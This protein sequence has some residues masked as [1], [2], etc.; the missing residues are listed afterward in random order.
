MSTPEQLGRWVVASATKHFYSQRGSTKMFIEGQNRDTDGLQVWYEFRLD[1]PFTILTT[2][3]QA[4]LDIEVNILITVLEANRDVYK[5]HEE[6]SKVA[7]MFS[8]C[9][10]LKRYG[11]AT[12]DVL[13]DGTQIGVFTLVAKGRDR[14]MTT[15]FGKVDPAVGIIQSTVEGHYECFIDLLEAIA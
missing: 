12:L 9:L 10:A 6:A 15:H 4:K 13:N 11:D 1:G 3:N 2:N 7:A 5:H 14:V 8:K